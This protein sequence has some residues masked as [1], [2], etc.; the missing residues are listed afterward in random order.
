[1]E[2]R[3][4]YERLVL[5]PGLAA[6]AIRALAP[7]RHHQRPLPVN[8]PAQNLPLGRHIRSHHGDRIVNQSGGDAHD[9]DCQHKE[10]CAAHH[11]DRGNADQDTALT[12]DLSWDTDGVPRPGILLIHGGGGL[13][14]HA[15]GQ[16]NRYAALGYAVF[17][18][19]MLGDGRG[20]P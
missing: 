19:D 4:L 18:C 3:M 16:A 1:M 13:D 12:G 14:H 20:R 8:H 7:S 5:T 9:S 6:G 11:V 10:D 17:G 15:R 2:R